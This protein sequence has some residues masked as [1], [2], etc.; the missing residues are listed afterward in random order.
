VHD[1]VPDCSPAREDGMGTSSV[2]TDSNSST[3]SLTSKIR[4][5]RS[6]K[7]TGPGKAAEGAC[8]LD[9]GYKLPSTGSTGAPEPPAKPDG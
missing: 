8:P 2:R 1:V 7:V 9:E 6:A 3:C 5:N 4:L